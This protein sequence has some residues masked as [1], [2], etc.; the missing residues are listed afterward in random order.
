MRRKNDR[1]AKKFRQLVDGL[2]IFTNRDLTI[3]RSET[4]NETM[5]KKSAISPD[6]QRLLDLMHDVYYGV[7]HDLHVRGGEPQLNPPP[8]VIRDIKLGRRTGR[9]PILDKNDFLLKEEVVDLLTHFD[10]LHDGTIAVVEI[11]AGL[12]DRIRVEGIPA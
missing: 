10:R 8:Y 12:P 11:R 6:R 4:M 3:E 9:R 1:I 2:R 7:M 5:I